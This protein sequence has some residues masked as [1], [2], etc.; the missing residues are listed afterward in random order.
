MFRRLFCFGKKKSEQGRENDGS[1]L[2]KD[3]P[4]ENHDGS[5]ACSQV[6]ALRSPDSEAA[7]KKKR[8]SAEVFSEA[9]GKLVEKLEGIHN[10]LDLQVHHN[11]QLVEKMDRLP[12]LLACLPNAVERQEK[13]FDEVTGQMRQKL[14]H[15]EQ[16]VEA[17]LGI[18][19][20]VSACAEME[21]KMSD[22]FVDLGRSLTRL[23][24]NTANQT[25]W[26]QHMNRS[27]ASNEQ[28]LR[29]TMSSQ[30]K[31]FYW[32]FGLSLGVSILTAAALA[33]VLIVLLNR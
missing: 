28:Y 30:Q 22:H 24:E 7:L 1:L 32:L 20:K 5:A 26:I 16:T 15:E 18:R 8:D 27:Y 6:V 23:G 13:L 19:E 21:G 10:S 25:E 11:Q 12:E 33:A 31:R 17:L 9:V 14:V 29:Q 4:A 2:I 3:Y